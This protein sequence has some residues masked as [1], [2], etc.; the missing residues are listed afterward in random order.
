MLN[1]RKKCLTLRPLPT[2][3]IVLGFQVESMP[4]FTTI[5]VVECHGKINPLYRDF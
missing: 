3:V 4:N 1:S 5:V 2:L